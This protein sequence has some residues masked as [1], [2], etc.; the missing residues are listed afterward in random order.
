MGCYIGGLVSQLKS[1]GE[2]RETIENSIEILD[3]AR[4]KGRN[5]IAIQSLIY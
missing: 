2:I 3:Q 4:Q 5:S 1:T